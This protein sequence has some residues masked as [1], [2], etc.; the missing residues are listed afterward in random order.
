MSDLNSLVRNDM[1]IHRLDSTRS[2]EPF[3]DVSSCPFSETRTYIVYR[4]SVA[5]QSSNS[6]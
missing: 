4:G 1:T 3:F 6:D 2:V 5:E